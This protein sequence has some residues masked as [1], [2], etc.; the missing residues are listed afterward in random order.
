MLGLA[1]GQT[2]K[3][4]TVDPIGLVTVR[5]Q[6][7]LLATRS[8]ADRTYR[9][10]RILAAEELAEPAQRPD[11]VDLDR[12]WQERSTRFRTGGDQVTVLLRVNPARREDLVGTALAVLAEEADADGWLRLEVTF[13]DSRHAEWALWQLATNAEA[14]S[15][16]WLRTSLRNRA[17]AIAT[18][19]EPSAGPTLPEDSGP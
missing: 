5:E 18:R 17:A 4:R 19:Y 3:W 7:Y 14:L 15:P 10:S 12:A 13:Q 6:G 2:P 9:L 1:V 16:Q 11:R 8:G